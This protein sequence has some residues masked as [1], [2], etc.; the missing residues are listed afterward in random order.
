MEAA[1]T[2]RAHGATGGYSDGLG[3]VSGSRRRGGQR[4]RGICHNSILELVA[5]DVGGVA[6]VG[7]RVP[8]QGYKFGVLVVDA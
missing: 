3:C 5:Q 8:S 6:G 2:R 1:A 4:L 7:G